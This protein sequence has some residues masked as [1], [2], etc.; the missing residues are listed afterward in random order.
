VI[1]QDAH[2]SLTSFQERANEL[3]EQYRQ[4]KAQRFRDSNG[5]L[6]TYMSDAYIYNIELPPYFTIARDERAVV[7][8]KVGGYNMVK[9]EQMLNRNIV[10]LCRVP[11]LTLCT[12]GHYRVL[13]MRRL[14]HGPLFQKFRAYEMRVASETPLLSPHTT[15]EIDPWLKKLAEKNG[16]SSA[17]NSHYLLHGTSPEALKQ[18]AKHG[19]TTARARESGSYGKGIYFTDTSCKAHQ[20]GDGNHT[21][22]LDRQR[23]GPGVIL[24][25]RVVL[26]RV[27]TLEGAAVGE[28]QSPT[29][30]HS[31]AALKDVT[32][33]VGQTYKQLH[34]EYVVFDDWACYPEFA[35]SIDVREQ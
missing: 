12:V 27:K 1:R 4:Q 35:L 9:A 6:L 11:P 23:P 33:Q 29:G 26:G 20:C 16:L 8:Y 22:L 28:R 3:V 34:N 30:F 2:E 13:G 15:P 25:C 14:E 7:D 19:L 5:R 32:H 31:V 24:I 17:A 21:G 18:I 10:E